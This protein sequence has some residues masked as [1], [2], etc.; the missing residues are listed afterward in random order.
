M[1]RS[2][3]YREVFSAFGRENKGGSYKILKRRLSEDGIDTSH[4]TQKGKMPKARVPTEEILVENSTFARSHLKTRLIR[5]GL[6]E[7][8]CSL[9]GQG[10]TWRGSSLTLVLDH[11]NGVSNDNRL[12]NLRFLCP[13]CNSQTDTFSGRNLPKKSHKMCPSCSTTILPTSKTCP[14]CRT[15][16]T[17]ISWPSSPDLEKMV[18]D[19]GYEGTGRTLGVS[20]N[21]VRKRLRNHAP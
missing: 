18:D 8:K 9:C 11:I 21:A 2:R 3:S 17:K 10:P 12:A 5:E 13:N 1:A 15:Q 4:F 7:Y 6:L 20:G 16:E 14:S 19:L